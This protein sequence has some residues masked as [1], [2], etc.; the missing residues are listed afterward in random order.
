LRGRIV[1]AGDGGERFWQ[2]VGDKADGEAA[3]G[4]ASA[5]LRWRSSTAGRSDGQIH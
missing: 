4:K 3:C 2:K 1:K 5:Y